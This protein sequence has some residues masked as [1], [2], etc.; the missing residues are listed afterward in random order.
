MTDV[1]EVIGVILKNYPAYPAS[2][3]PVL[4][5]TIPRHSESIYSKRYKRPLSFLFGDID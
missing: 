4:I 5:K 2:S 1:L 3:P